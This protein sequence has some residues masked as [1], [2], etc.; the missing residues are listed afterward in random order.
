MHLTASMTCH[1]WQVST[2]AI[3]LTYVALRRWEHNRF[4]LNWADRSTLLD[5]DVLWAHYTRSAERSDYVGGAFAATASLPAD[6]LSCAGTCASKWGWE[7]PVSSAACCSKPPPARRAAPARSLRE[8]YASDRQL[9]LTSC[10]NGDAGGG[11]TG[12]STG[13]LPVRHL[14]GILSRTN[15]ADERYELRR[16]LARTPSSLT[17]H[18]P[19]HTRGG[20][21]RMLRYCFVFDATPPHGGVRRPG[22]LYNTRAW[23]LFEAGRRDDFDLTA[24]TP[25]ADFPEVAAVT[26]AVTGGGPAGVAEQEPTA[27]WWQRAAAHARGAP[28][29]FDFY[30]LTT[31]SALLTMGTDGQ[32]TLS[33]SATRRLAWLPRS[34]VERK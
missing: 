24:L 9:N 7:A 2:R 23:L 15:Q 26:R 21:P 25:D 13:E 14:V 12:A 1:M 5:G 11:G 30:A 18:A 6:G 17:A 29:A 28:H 34:S 20:A 4:W 31:A 19:A 33:E 8:Q 22:Q 32:A 27:R 16:L 3:P 10:F